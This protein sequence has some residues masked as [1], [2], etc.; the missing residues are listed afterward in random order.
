MYNTL[1]SYCDKNLVEITTVTHF[2]HQELIYFSSL[3]KNL[4]NTKSKFE[5]KQIEAFLE[6]LFLPLSSVD[7]YKHPFIIDRIGANTECSYYIEDFLREKH[8]PQGLIGQT[9]NRMLC[10]DFLR[11]MFTFWKNLFP[12]HL[13]EPFI[14]LLFTL[15]GEDDSIQ[16]GVVTFM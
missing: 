15:C 12:P 5:D 9:L 7:K 13:L 8:F 3:Y 4:I 6:S 2:L 16:V 10:R 11:R 14:A 1:L